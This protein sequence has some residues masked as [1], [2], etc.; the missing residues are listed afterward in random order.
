VAIAIALLKLLARGPA[1][2]GELTQALGVS[3]PTL[4]RLLRPLERSGRVV[5]LGSTRGARYGLAREVGAVGTT[6]PLY[7]I[8]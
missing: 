7:L 8:D 5:R 6:W 3:Q 4:S 1:S 2:S